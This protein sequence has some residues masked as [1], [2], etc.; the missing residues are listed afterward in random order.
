MSDLAR[1]ARDGAARDRD[2]DQY[3]MRL[4][5]RRLAHVVN[6]SCNIEAT[7][8]G[9]AYNPAFVNPDD[10]QDLGLSPG[11]EVTICS[12]VATI[13]AIVQPEPGLRRG[14]VS[15]MFGFGD[16]PDRDGEYRSIGAS[17]SRLVATDRVFDRFI[18]QPRMSNIPVTIVPREP[19]RASAPDPATTEQL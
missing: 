1:L 13:P 12:S 11:S 17:P 7:N 9:R 8:H 10:M 3:P 2:D 4:V 14:V 5:C 16:G 19:A 18:G 15:M 6:S